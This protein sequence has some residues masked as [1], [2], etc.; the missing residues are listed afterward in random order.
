MK[1]IRVMVVDDSA[2]LRRTLSAM[3]EA[4][5]QISVIGTAENGQEAVEMAKSLRPDVITLDVIM[6][7]MDG[8]T[9][10]R[11]ILE[12]TN[13]RVL[14]VSSVTRDG[15][16]Q[17]LEA[18]SLGAVDFITK[19]SGATSLDIH[20]IRSELIRKVMTAYECRRPR[21][22]SGA[23]AARKFKQ[24]AVDISSRGLG[25]SDVSPSQSPR[26]D[27]HHTELIAIAAS[28]GG[29]AALQVVLAG[30]PADLPA[31]VV[32]VQHIA[33]GF[34]VPLADRLNSISPLAIKVCEGSEIIRPGTA[35]LAP[36]GS[37]LTLRR[38]Q[39]RLYALLTDEP[40]DALHRPS[41]NVL[42][43][44]VA[45]ICGPSA[46]AVILTGMG[47]DGA[48]G[49]KEI[50]DSGGVTIAQDEATSVIYGMPRAAVE[51]GGIRIVAAL[52]KIS[53]RILASLF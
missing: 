11:H 45:R 8:I 6:P 44:S 28:T 32:I 14:M 5:P 38:T 43:H 41:A 24:I 25:S 21:P 4:E 18:L 30:L 10:L 12:F 37:H 48:E 9:A 50:K 33:Q 17:T 26:S 1:N 23:D 29:P 16:A 20:K 49:I 2:F 13:A 7:V 51:K 40:A 31:G 46:C 42:F 47:E 35:L 22:V 15:A 52:D 27:V 34:D 19:P 36:T 53:V 3:L 39:G